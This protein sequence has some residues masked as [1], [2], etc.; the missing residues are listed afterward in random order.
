V[1]AGP[2]LRPELVEG[3]CPG[4]GVSPPQHP[5]D[6]R[7]PFALDIRVSCARYSRPAAGHLP[8]GAERRFRW[9][10]GV[11]G[12]MILEPRPKS[13]FRSPDGHLETVSQRHCH[14]RAAGGDPVRQIPRH[15]PL[16]RGARQGAQGRVRAPQRK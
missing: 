9:P 6:P 2:V 3:A 7:L 13:K 8:R 4:A 11:P 1:P 16:G 10:R 5:G 15:A 12:A 14:A